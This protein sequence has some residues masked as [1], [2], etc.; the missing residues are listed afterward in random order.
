MKYNA[1]RT[2]MEI[3]NGIFNY[4]PTALAHFACIVHSGNFL[5]NGVAYRMGRSSVYSM[6]S[7][8]CTV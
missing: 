4:L 1:Q 8:V 3:I 2:E 6:V 5:F 7:Y